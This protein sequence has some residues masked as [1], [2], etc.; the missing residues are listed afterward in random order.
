VSRF[1]REQLRV[2]L[3]RMGGGQLMS[4]DH[5]LQG[6]I[7]LL[8]AA[9]DV[10]SHCRGHA[11]CRSLGPAVRGVQRLPRRRPDQRDP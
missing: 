8:H 6:E 9:C 3:L 1:A 10:L 5:R 7:D 2:A 4:A 11:G